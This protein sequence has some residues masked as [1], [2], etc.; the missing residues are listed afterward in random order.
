MEV[1]NFSQGGQVNLDTTFRTTNVQDSATSTTA[2]SSDSNANQDGA[3]VKDSP[4]VTESTKDVN[5]KDVKKAVDKLNKFL[6]GETTHVEYEAHD[7]YKHDI[8]IKIVDNN[9]GKV[10]MEVPPKKILDMV[11]KMCEMVGVLVDKKA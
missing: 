1:R 3:M 7:V 2:A 11:A 5:E 8:I 10:I 4:K 6:E 9:T